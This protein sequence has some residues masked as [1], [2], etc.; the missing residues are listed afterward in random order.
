MIVFNVRVAV[1]TTVAVNRRVYWLVN[2][3][4]TSH[5]NHKTFSSEYFLLEK[6]ILMHFKREHEDLREMD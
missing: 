2:L 6:K 5:Y 3:E 1:L 4:T